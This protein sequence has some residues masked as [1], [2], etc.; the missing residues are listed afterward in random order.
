MSPT[1]ILPNFVSITEIAGDMD[2]L[3][4]QGVLDTGHSDHAVADVRAL[5]SVASCVFCQYKF[6]YNPQYTSESSDFLV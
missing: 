6:T 3:Q 5:H 1:E 4:L 2:I